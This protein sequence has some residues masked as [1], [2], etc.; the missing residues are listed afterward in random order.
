VG[1]QDNQVTGKFL[2][3]PEDL[4]GGLA[5]LEPVSNG[6]RLR[7]SLD[8]AEHLPQL[9]PIAD[10]LPARHDLPMDDWRQINVHYHD[11]STV[12]AGQRAGHLKRVD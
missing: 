12:V 10:A 9:L 11:R 5:F 7:R 6:N 4:C 8:P 2:G 3:S 1:A